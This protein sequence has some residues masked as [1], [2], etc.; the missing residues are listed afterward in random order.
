MRRR[1]ASASETL[2]TAP[3]AS[4]SFNSATAAVSRS[5]GKDGVGLPPA[6]SD[7]PVESVV[8]M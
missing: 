3:A 1:Y 2:V 6:D 8:L 7:G 5:A 4:R